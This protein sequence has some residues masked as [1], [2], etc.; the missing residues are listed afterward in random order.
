MRVESILRGH[1]PAHDGIKEGFPL[2]SVEPKDLEMTIMRKQSS[3]DV[4]DKEFMNSKS[5]K[6]AVERHKK[7]SLVH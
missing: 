3:R 2:T 7:Y 5:Q 4:L 6:E 1:A